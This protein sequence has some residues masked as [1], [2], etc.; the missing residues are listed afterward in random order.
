MKKI[1]K[2]A[3]LGLLICGNSTA[4]EI[5]D[6]E[7]TANYLTITY[8][9]ETARS[10]ECTA[11]NSENKPIGGGIGFFTAKVTRAIIEVPMK[12]SGK[13]LKLNCKPK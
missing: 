9:H 5:T 2:I 7:W 1:L 11:Y 6:T 12:Y 3:V 4:N 8:Y 13:N 10:V